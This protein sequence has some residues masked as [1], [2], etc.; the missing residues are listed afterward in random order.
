MISIVL[1]KI[2]HDFMS[3]NLA[4]DPAADSKTMLSGINQKFNVR[5][6]YIIRKKKL[7]ICHITL[8]NTTIVMMS[9][10]NSI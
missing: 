6:N 3:G 4:A 1:I 7:R 10:Q 2:Y 9:E 8:K 5:K